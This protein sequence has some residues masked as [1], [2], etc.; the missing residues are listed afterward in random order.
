[1]DLALTPSQEEF[2]LEARTWL[3]AHLRPEW[4]RPG[5]LPPAGDP[6]AFEALSCWE[7]QL[8][9]AGFIGLSWPVASGGRGLGPTEEYL[10]AEEYALARAPERLNVIGVGLAGPTLLA[11]GTDDQRKAFL[12]GIVSGSE[13]WCQGF[14]EPEAGSDL[15]SLRCRAER[16]GGEWVVSGQK[17]WTS[18]AHLARWCLLLVRSDPQAPK[19]RGITCVVLDMSAP[20]V[21]IRPL[22]QATGEPRFNELFL[23]RV[24]VPLER[25]VGPIHGGWGVAMDTLGFERGGA[26]ASHVR[27]RLLVEDLLDLAREHG[28]ASEALLRQ[29]LSAAYVDAELF[30]M[31][32]LR[33][34]AGD[35][36]GR[37]TPRV[38]A[39]G[40]LYWSEMFARLGDL[41]LSILG[42]LGMTAAD[43]VDRWQ[44]D[45]LIGRA[46][47]IYAGTSEI[48]RNLISERVLG[49]P[50]D[51]N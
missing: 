44:R 3:A 40:K 10:F 23:D 17:L 12:P 34:L 43:G 4:R 13:I 46:S 47:L 51:R 39:I 45:A 8:G 20:G 37:P 35:V 30:R 6:A 15:G 26:L 28:K 42:P 32:C 1:M 22:V 5:V 7:Q 33:A 21:E 11:H 18:F 49:L 25:T 24:R 19:H 38:S 29:G 2:A 31:N 9:K 27:F 41:A 16:D 48:Q 14:S 50:R 36:A